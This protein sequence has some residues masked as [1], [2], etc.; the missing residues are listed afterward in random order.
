VDEGSSVVLLGER[1]ANGRFPLGG[2]RWALERR[3]RRGG[4]LVSLDPE[5][6]RR[7]V[8][9]VRALV[10]EAV[11]GG[12]TRSPA[13]TTAGGGLG[14]ALAEMAVHAGTGAEL[15][16]IGGFDE[17]FCELPSRALVATTDPDGLLGRAADAGCR[18]ACSGPQAGRAS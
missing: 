3:A 18:R 11:A 1:A 17:L 9:L 10:A 15:G 14:V 4:T 7:L 6:H 5:A 12:Q 2:S 16:G 13:C 8:E